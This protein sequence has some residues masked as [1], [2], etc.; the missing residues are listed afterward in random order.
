MAAVT[1]LLLL[2]NAV[3]YGLGRGPLQQ[4]PPAGGSAAA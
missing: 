4:A 1:T 2:A 3:R